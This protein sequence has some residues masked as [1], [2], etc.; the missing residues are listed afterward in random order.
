[1]AKNS[2]I[3]YNSAEHLMLDALHIRTDRESS[4]AS[5]IL[6]RIRHYKKDHSLFRRDKRAY[7]EQ[8]MELINSLAS[9]KINRKDHDHLERLLD[10]P[11]FDKND[12]LLN[13]DCIHFLIATSNI[14]IDDFSD[15]PEIGSM[16]H[17]KYHKLEKYSYLLHQAKDKKRKNV[18]GKRNIKRYPHIDDVK[19]MVRIAKSKS[20][21]I[22]NKELWLKFNREWKGYKIDGQVKTQ[23]IFKG[24]PPEGRAIEPDVRPST[25]HKT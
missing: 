4:S 13:I 23:L 24:F 1:M 15:G 8:E 14:D 20:P 2:A 21:D 6:H 11:L 25:K 12:D 17:M 5:E 10:A 19:K 3:Y 7:I 16:L 22:K 18:T 9:D